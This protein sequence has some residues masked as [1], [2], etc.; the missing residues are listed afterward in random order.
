[1]SQCNTTQTST[2]TM[3]VCVRSRSGL[4]CSS[5]ARS[6]A[7]GLAPFLRSSGRP[8]YRYATPWTCSAS[9]MC[10]RRTSQYCVW[11]G[12]V[13]R[14]SMHIEGSPSCSITST[15]SMVIFKVL[16]LTGPF[17]VK[18]VLHAPNTSPTSLE[19][20]IRIRGEGFA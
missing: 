20:V 3:S 4:S 11:L 13:V 10:L 12:L 7:F 18:P 8:A 6:W 5:F 16:H 1:M 19:S 15:F 9:G 14:G 2:A 17:S